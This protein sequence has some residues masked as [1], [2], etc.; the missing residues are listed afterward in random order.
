MGLQ[1][2]DYNYCLNILVS[3]WIALSEL[4]D[5][6]ER[7]KWGWGQCDQMVKYYFQDWAIKKIKNCPIS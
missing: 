1:P 6:N 5:H 7:E 4:Y 3:T 2:F